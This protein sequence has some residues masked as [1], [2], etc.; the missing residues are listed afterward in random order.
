MKENAFMRRRI[1]HSIAT[2]SA[3]QSPRCLQPRS[4]PPAV[5]YAPYPLLH[6]RFQRAI[7]RLP[8]PWEMPVYSPIRRTHARLATLHTA[9]RP[10]YRFHPTAYTVS[11][12]RCTHVGLRGERVGSGMP[13]PGARKPYLPA[14]TLHWAYKASTR[15]FIDMPFSGFLAPPS[16]SSELTRILQPSILLVY[17]KF[18]SF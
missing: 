11:K 9:Q 4:F 13:L 8:G 1:R 15:S 18:R 12:K 17:H 2:E 10:Q 5:L 3:L 6:A 14:P 16:G 7:P